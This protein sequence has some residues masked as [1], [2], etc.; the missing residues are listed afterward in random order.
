MLEVLVLAVLLQAPDIAGADQ[1]FS[2]G[3]FAEAQERYR[4]LLQQMPGQ[5]ALLLRLGAC[6]YQLGNF[7]AAEDSFRRAVRAQPELVPALLGLGTSLVA[8]GRPREGSPFLEHA[9]KLAPANPL[10]RRALGHAY[11]EAEEFLKGE[12]VLRR[13]VEEDPQDWESWFYLGTLFFNRHYD[14]P[15]ISALEAS[16]KIQPNNS[17]AQI[18]RA[19]ALSQIG[20]TQ[21]AEDL[22]RKLTNDPKV[23]NS[24]ELLLGYAQF[25]FQSERQDEA[26]AKIDGA[27]EAAPNSAKLHFWKARILLYMNQTDSA[28]REAERS[29]ALAPEQPHARNLLLRMYR[30]QGRDREAAK[31]AE[32]LR[33]YETKAALGAG[34]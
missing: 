17:Q 26:L 6:E 9:V 25:L 12:E 5:A 31:Q 10:A 8:L 15:A 13:L 16:L 22:F 19:G 14:L 32:W 21:E 33:Q 18:Y 27:L 29:V 24:P 2:T 7:V 11:V 4:R 30:I 3:H 23:A 28:I 34:R 1:L 20:R